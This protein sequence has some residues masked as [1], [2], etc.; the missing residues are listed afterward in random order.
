MANLQIP[1]LPPVTALSGDEQFEAVQANTSVRVTFRQFKTYAGS[2]VI[3]QVP[4]LAALKALPSPYPEAVM[5]KCRNTEGDQGGGTWIFRAGDQ[6]AAVTADTQS[7]VWA[8]PDSAPSGASGAWQRLYDGPLNSLWFGAFPS[9]TAAQNVTAFNAACA[10][11]AQKTL[12]IPAGYYLIDGTISVPA[13]TYLVGEG[14]NDLFNPTT[15]GTVI[16]VTHTS[17]PAFSVIDGVVIDGINFWWPNQVVTNPPTAY[18]YAIYCDLS[19]GTIQG[20]TIKNVTMYNAYNGIDLNGSWSAGVPTATNLPRL[21]H[22]YGCFLNN[23]IRQN[24]LVTEATMLECNFSPVW[25]RAAAAYAAANPGN[26]ALSWM[27][28]SSVGCYHIKGGQG[29]QITGGTFFGHRRGIYC[30]NPTGVLSDCSIT[31]LNVSNFIFDGIRKCVEVADQ[32]GLN[33]AR[34]DG[35]TFLGSDRYGA[36]GATDCRALYMNDSQNANILEFNGCSFYGTQ[37]SHVEIVAPT[38]TSVGRYK[39]A[40]CFFYNANANNQAGTFYNVYCDDARA[41]VVIEGA[42]VYNPTSPAQIKCFT[43]VNAQV[44]T[45]TD[46]TIADTASQAFEISSAATYMTVNGVYSRSTVASVWPSS[47]PVS[48]ASASAV[49][50]WEWDMP[51]VTITGTTTITSIVL[52]WTGRVVTLKFSSAGCTVTDGGNLILSG[53]FVSAVNGATLT[54]ACDGT[55]WVEVGR[56]NSTDITIASGTLTA[57]DPAIN[58]TQT[59]NN[60]GGIFNSFSINNTDTASNIS[61]TFASFRMAGVAKFNFFKD[62]TLLSTGNLGAGYGVSTGTTTLSLGSARTGDGIANI[63]L[64]SDTTYTSG[65]LRIVRNAGANGTSTLTHRGTGGFGLIASEAATFTLTLNSVTALTATSTALTAAVPFNGT[66]AA[67]SGAVTGYST[68]TGGS[69]SRT[70]AAHFSDQLN[71]KDFGAVGDGTTNDTAAI[72]AALAASPVFVPSGTYDTTTA[73]FSG[74]GWG[75]G[76]LRDSSNDKWAPY[77]STVDVA[78]FPEGTHTSISTAFNGDISRVQLAMEHRITGATTLGQPTTG[79]RYVPE[80]YPV[81]G[82]LYNTSGHNQ[83]TADNDGR[84]AAVFS[85]VRVYNAG[86]GDAVAYNASA[87]VIGAKAGAT[88]VLANP[89]AVLFNG[90]T[91]AGADG[92]YLNPVEINT[93]GG[94][95]DVAAANFVA[96]QFRDVDT[97]ALGAFWYGYRSQSKGAAKID[98][99]FSLYGGAKIGID[100]TGLTSNTSGTWAYGA[101]ALKADQRIYLNAVA[102][103]PDPSYASSL[104]TTWIEYDTSVGGLLF[105]AGGVDALT[106]TSTALTAGVPLVVTGGT[107]TASTPV[108]SATQTWNNAAVTFNGIYF[109]ATST[110][111]AATSLLMSL[112]TGGVNAFSVRKDGTVTCGGSAVIAAASGYYWLGRSA[113]LSPSDGVIQLSNNALTDFTRLQFGGTTSS[114]PSIKRN[115]A[116]FD[117]RLADDSGYASLTGATLT[118]AA[119]AI[120]LGTVYARYTTALPAGGTANH[121]I[122]LFS[123]ANFGIFA[124]SG[125]PTLSAAQGSLYLRSDG[126]GTND[127]MYVNTNGSTT[128]T[129]VVTV[130]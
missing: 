4:D 24:A 71:V 23:G 92:V 9:N 47:G 85:R 12:F 94:V 3:D 40:G 103:S 35:C 96:N 121:G 52:S 11:A 1:N 100:F 82:W 69:A 122:R 75:I 8:A 102:G 76:Q 46:I 26:S 50:L 107:V 63:D 55:N 44:L 108:F 129:A 39:F 16:G 60:A 127:R 33:G 45:L 97:G 29:M 117:L 38:S 28:S 18:D 37:G 43:V 119:D 62:G 56:S 30:S 17:G 57:S 113:M 101:M 13:G 90:E 99:H 104:G 128:W 79:Y 6:S 67:F 109:N 51:Y 36:P 54:L 84:T 27:M 120:A 20:P 95:Y 7:G 5:T 15:T 53:N 87:F 112:Q 86:Q 115:A 125:A 118:A 14:G 10:A 98:A 89:A 116:A 19:G 32:C 78:P 42:Y 80:A 91:I 83:G 2:L 74:R 88:S 81:Y 64:V 106:A 70:L 25:W 126:T 114:F 68:A 110:A 111:S 41:Q 73:T 59:W 105:R 130:A 61:S 31:F 58:I 65:G 66:T 72:T 77:F 22:I 124:G 21:E 49:T 48:I 123:T 93:Q 34:F